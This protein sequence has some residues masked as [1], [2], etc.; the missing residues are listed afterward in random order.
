[1]VASGPDATTVHYLRNY[2]VL[3]DWDLVLMDAGCEWHGYA[4]DV[5]RTWPVNGKF[6]K[7]QREIYEVVRKAH[8]ACLA[9]VRPGA[10]LRQLQ[11]TSVRV[12]TE[13]LHSL[14]LVGGGAV[15]AAGAYRRFYPHSLGHWLGMDTHD[16][17]V[18]SPDQPML[19][20]VVLTV[21]PGL[22]VPNAAAY[23]K[24]AGLGVRL[25]DDV[26]V[27]EGGAEVLSEGLPLRP[28]DVEG[29]LEDLRG[30]V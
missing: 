27:T 10:T 30:S 23:G 1:M 22:Y 21:E 7:E 5:T 24:Y 13:G 15:A 8:A 11:A 20:G 19:P 18:V 4:S 16:V 17:P 28:E 26:L 2:K 25:E 9:Q 14:G 6:S 29:L 3:A 12:V